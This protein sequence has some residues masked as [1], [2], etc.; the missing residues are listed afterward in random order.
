M[1]GISDVIGNVLTRGIDAAQSVLTTKFTVSNPNPNS[2]TANGSPVVAGSGAFSVGGV[3][4]TPVLLVG[5]AVLLA[6]LLLRRK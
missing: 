3:N 2:S 5:G 6:V 1:A 4:L